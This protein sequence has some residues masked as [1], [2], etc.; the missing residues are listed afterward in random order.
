MSVSRIFAQE[1]K[2]AYQGAPCAEHL[3]QKRRASTLDAVKRQGEYPSK[4]SAAFGA[5]S[6]RSARFAA[7][8]RHREVNRWNIACARRNNTLTSRRKPSTRSCPAR[9][10][11]TLRAR[12]YKPSHIGHMVGPYLRHRQGYFDGAWATSVHWI[13]NI[14]DVDGKLIH[15]AGLGHHSQGTIERMTADYMNASRSCSPAS[16]ACRKRPGTSPR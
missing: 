2:L 7:A 4:K 12:V 5:A 15:R 6:D 14:T 10:A 9:S 16:T 8:D 13:V 3:C 11:C 1:P